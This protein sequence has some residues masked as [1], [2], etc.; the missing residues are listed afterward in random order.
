MP[1]SFVTTVRIHGRD[2]NVRSYPM[3]RHVRIWRKLT[4][5]LI[6]DEAGFDPELT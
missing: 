3:H 1:N 5:D 2:A 6:W 4:Y